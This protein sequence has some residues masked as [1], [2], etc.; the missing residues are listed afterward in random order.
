MMPHSK[1]MKKIV[2]AIVKLL[3][4]VAILPTMLFL[5]S[6]LTGWGYFV[7]EEGYLHRYI[8][9]GRTVTIPSNVTVI[10]MHAFSDMNVFEDSNAFD[11]PIKKI[12]TPN[13][14]M[15]YVNIPDNVIKIERAAFYNCSSLKS[16]NIPDSVTYI[17]DFAFSGCTS[18]ASVHLP[19][20]LTII[21]IAL[22]EDCFSLKTVNIPEGVKTI[23][24]G[25][26]YRCFS[27]DALT[28]P[29][30]VTSIDSVAFRSCE[31]LTTLHIPK[32]VTSLHANAFSGCVNLASIT[33]DELNPNFTSIDG[34][35]FSNAKLKDDKFCESMK[36][37]ETYPPGNESTVYIV[38]DNVIAI[39]GFAFDDAIYLNKVH[40]SSN[41]EE[42][43]MG[44][45]YG[46]TNLTDVFIPKSVKT[47][48]SSN[49]GLNEVFHGCEGLTIHGALG[50]HA[51]KYALSKNI[52]FVSVDVLPESY[53]EPFSNDIFFNTDFAEIE[54]HKGVY[55][56]SRRS[57]RKYPHIFGHI[58]IPR[59][60]WLDIRIGLLYG[61]RREV[62]LP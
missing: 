52:S 48:F 57:R 44:A 38:P 32:N 54:V 5:T 7:I 45:F 1:K 2:F 41:V 47:I 29:E 42:I 58:P 21:S 19:K 43:G 24:S 62:E 4:V 49:V 53:E 60:K 8:G 14:F 40:I 55:L 12:K 16:I 26:F 9:F 51:E 22:F 50:S 3:L 39:G 23:E 35:L 10:G 15:K 17:G 36:I 6:Y 61:Q 25:A 20:D 13:I 33:V 18:L 56:R 11:N 37:L 46:C 30:S 31:S 28:I 59:A 34:V 27:L